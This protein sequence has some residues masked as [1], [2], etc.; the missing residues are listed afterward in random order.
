MNWIE[1]AA[2]KL[3]KKNQVLFAK[4]SD[5]LQDLNILFQSQNHRVLTLW[6]S[7]LP[8]NQLNG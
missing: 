5:Y 2:I 3:K 6:R 8:P 7:T 1:E 4:N